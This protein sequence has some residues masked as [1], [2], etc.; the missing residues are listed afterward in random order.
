MLRLLNDTIV[1]L[2]LKHL[3]YKFVLLFQKMLIQT[4]RM[5]I[6]SHMNYIIQLILPDDNFRFTCIFFCDT[7]L[8]KV[9]TALGLILLF[10]LK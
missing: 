8:L 10:F 2:L 7:F 1:T 6:S 4:Y 3:F 5:M 9:K